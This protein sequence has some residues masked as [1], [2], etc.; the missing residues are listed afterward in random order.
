MRSCLAGHIYALFFSLSDK[1]YALGSGY[2]AYM[3]S[4]ARLFCQCY[5][6][7]HHLPFALGRYSLISQFLC[8]DSVVNVFP[9]DERLYLAVSRY[10][11]VDSR[12]S[13]HGF[14]HEVVI[15]HSGS[16][17]R[18]PCQTY[19]GVFRIKI[20]RLTTKRWP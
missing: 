20:L 11:A 16:V 12:H 18:K 4:A 15:L 13:Y 9:P 3:I 2:M 14:S 19:F 6:P 8:E 1:F 7:F 5:I 10:D 17:I